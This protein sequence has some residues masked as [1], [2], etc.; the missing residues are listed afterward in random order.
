MNNNY[1]RV[2]TCIPKVYL[3]KP[4]QNVDEILQELSKIKDADIVLLPEL[5]I[6]GYSNGDWFLNQEFINVG[7]E[8]TKKLID[9]SNEQVWIVGVP[10]SID[11]KL[12]NVALV[13]QN[14]KVLGAVPKMHLPSYR[15]F[16]EKRIFVD[17]L[18]YYLNN[19]EI[20]KF[21]Q[22]FPFGEAIFY[23]NSVSFGIEICEDLWQNYA[24]HIDLYNE[25]AHIVFN[26]STSTFQVDKKSRRELLCNNASYLGSGAYVYVSTGVSETSSDIIYSGHTIF[27]ELGTTLFSFEALNQD[28]FIKVMDIDIEK[29]E[30]TRHTLN[31]RLVRHNTGIRRIPYCLRQGQVN[32]L[33]LRDIDTFPF[34]LKTNDTKQEV[35]DVLARALYNRLTHIGIKKVVLG[36]SGGLDSTCA[37]LVINYCFEKYNLNK[38]GII[39]LTMPGLGTGHKSKNNA[40]TLAK[41][42][43][44]NLIEKNIEEEVRHHFALIGKDDDKADI[45]YENI[46]ARYRTLLLMNLANKENAIVCGTGDMSEIALGWSTFN[47]DQMSMYNLNGGLPKTTIREVVAYFKTIYPESIKPIQDVIDLPIS[48]E[49]TSSDQLTEDI[50]GK[51]EINDF[52]MYHIFICGASKSRIIALLKQGFNLTE[53][54]SKSYYDNFMRRFCRNQ[55]KRLTGPETVKIFSFSFGARSDLH[56]P[57]DMKY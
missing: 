2:A 25:G 31:N 51:Y 44:I 22:K 19:I 1:L 55:F 7:E 53:D 8:A 11:S 6:T 21:G 43:G 14:K 24:P 16:F 9:A 28:S 4:I 57:G 45:T 42:L 20:E 27:S 26:L 23:N 5:A 17:G 49:L 47:G 12:F 48:P 18:D 13:I 41:S 50:I 40:Y 36:V 29:I 33:I 54:T 10:L 34:S 38:D 15:E 37:L 56:F 30:Y 35:I 39:A 32:S 3:G 46:Q 52:I